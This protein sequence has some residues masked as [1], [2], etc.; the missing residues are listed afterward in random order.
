M[1]WKNQYNNHQ[2]AADAM[3][4]C[5]A[6]RALDEPLMVVPIAADSVRQSELAR[7]SHQSSRALSSLN[8]EGNKRGQCYD[9][10]SQTTYVL[11]TYIYCTQFSKLPRVVHR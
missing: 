4:I 2:M 6:R 1:G 8:P 5:I 11:D 10:R 7:S 9:S 3:I